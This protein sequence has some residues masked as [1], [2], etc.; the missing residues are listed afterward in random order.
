MLP[1]NNGI[2]DNEILQNQFTAYVRRAVHNCRLRYITTQVRRDCQELNFSQIQVILIAED[3]PI[4]KALECEY[5]RDA[6]RHV[7]STERAIILARVIE[8]KSFGTIAEEMG[9]T[10][11]AVTNIYYRSM[12]RLK[13]YMEGADRK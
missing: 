8:E 1:K 12:K 4:E 3:D 10:Y 11:K 7:Q 9:L 13:A 5:I 2:T 6:L